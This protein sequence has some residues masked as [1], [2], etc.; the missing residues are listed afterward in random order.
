[1]SDTREPAVIDYVR[2]DEERG[3]TTWVG[4]K[5]LPPSGWGQGFGGLLLDPH[6]LADW[7]ASLAVLFG[8]KTYDEIVGR[9]CF[10][11]RC[12]PAYGADIEGLEVDGRRFTITDFR[13]KHW[14]EKARDQLTNKTEAIRR[15]IDYHARRIREQVA[16]LER[17]SDG[18]VE[19]SV[20]HESAAHNGSEFPKTASQTNNAATVP[21]QGEGEG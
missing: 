9:H 21:E 5:G 4:T 19:W 17:A 6:H 8:V 12:W 16:A 18:Y 2:D 13:R 1:M 15:D 7:K 20:P 10:V 14:P 11:L 3:L